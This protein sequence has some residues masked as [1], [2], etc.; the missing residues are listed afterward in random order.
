[1]GPNGDA[2]VDDV[3]SV[4]A[5]VVPAAAHVEAV[6]A[7]ALGLTRNALVALVPGRPREGGITGVRHPNLDAASVVIEEGE[8]VVLEPR[9]QVRA[10]VE[11]IAPLVSHAQHV[12]G[13][14]RL[15]GA[16]VHEVDVL[17][18]GP[19]VAEGHRLSAR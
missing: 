12:A 9:V 7:A 11:R 18:G 2:P 5:G 16:E 1:Q 19:I 3:L 6:A 15:E 17:A 14:R 4:I 10:D 8:R 13:A